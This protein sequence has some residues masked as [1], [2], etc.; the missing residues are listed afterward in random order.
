M[1]TPIR[2]LVVD[3]DP[4]ARRRVR[5][6]LEGDAEIEVVGEAANGR[7]AV[8]RIRELRPCLRS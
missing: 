8:E 1:S 5:G 3:D 7:E 6:L 4:L 2:T